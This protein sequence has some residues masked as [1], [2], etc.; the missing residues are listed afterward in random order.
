[1]ASSK[2]SIAGASLGRTV[3]L[4]GTPC[5]WIGKTG[6]YTFEYEYIYR[7][8][9]RYIHRKAIESTWKTRS[10]PILHG[11]LSPKANINLHIYSAH[12]TSWDCPWERG[13]PTK[14]SGS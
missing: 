7:Y 6:A 2:C 14:S 11:T 12:V 13:E 4:E 10:K 9:Y 3:L 1:M 5:N 8:R